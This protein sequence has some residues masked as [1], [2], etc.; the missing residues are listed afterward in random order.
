[1]DRPTKFEEGQIF[2]FYN[3]K[4]QQHHQFVVSK[5]AMNRVAAIFYDGSV[6][7]FAQDEVTFLKLTFVK[8]F[9]T[10]QEAVLS[11]E[12]NSEAA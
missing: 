1:M 8:K 7:D 6:I 4:Q 2:Q 5:A 3:P 9:D 12:F 11:K 10:W